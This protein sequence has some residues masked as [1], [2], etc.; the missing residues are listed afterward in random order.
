MVRPNHAWCCLTTHGAAGYDG[1]NI[2]SYASLAEPGSN[3]M[4]LDPE[5]PGDVI[6]CQ[7]ALARVIRTKLVRRILCN[8]R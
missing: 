4:C 7:H 1:S 5:H 3:G 2:E 8:I 6:I